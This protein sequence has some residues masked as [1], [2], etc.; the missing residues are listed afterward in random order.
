MLQIKLLGMGDT[1]F[2]KLKKN[3]LEALRSSAIPFKLEEV[4]DIESFLS[5]DLRSIPTIVIN[6]KVFF[7][8]KYIPN[9]LELIERLESVSSELIINA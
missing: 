6:D 4:K 2:Q 7:Q 8:D 3:L 1:A 9:V 5:Y